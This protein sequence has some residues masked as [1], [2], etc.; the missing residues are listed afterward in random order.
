[1]ALEKR[2]HSKKKKKRKPHTY[3]R[4][5]ASISHSYLLVVLFYAY[6]LKVLSVAMS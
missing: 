4:L 2:N 3:A 1:M 6:A 5:A